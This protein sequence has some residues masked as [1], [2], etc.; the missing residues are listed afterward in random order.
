MYNV[1]HTCCLIAN[2]HDQ[3]DLHLTIIACM[4]LK[5]DEAMNTEPHSSEISA[6]SRVHEMAPNGELHVCCK[7]QIKWALLVVLGYYVSLGLCARYQPQ[8]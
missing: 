3:I 8:V 6:E 1:L 7:T 5:R 2:N 4:S